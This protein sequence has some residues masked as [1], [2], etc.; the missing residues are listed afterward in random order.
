MTLRHLKMFIAV[1][2]AGSITS[3]AKTLFVAQPTVS[4]AIL[5]LERHYNVKL[6]DR[7]SKKLYLT[8]QGKRLLGYA[9]HVTSLVTE[10][11]QVSRDHDKSGLL[12]I[13]AS[14]TIGACL[15]PG[16][17]KQFM[18]ENPAMQVQAIVKNTQDIEALITANAIDFA[19]VEG[20][21][22]SPSLITGTFA[23]DQLVLACGRTHPLYKA[24][25]LSL[26]E[27]SR[28]DFI[29]RE[30]G[31]GTRE[32]FENTMAAHEVKWQLIWDCNGSD[33]LK[34]AAINGLGIA[35]IS[36]RL[37]EHELVTGE[38]VPLICNELSLKRSF[39][40]TYHKNK[41]L[42]AAMKKFMILCHSPFETF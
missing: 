22:H 11:E 36:Q 32:L 17:I 1:A 40:I 13:G 25:P 26:A 41:Y 38:L 39:C 42:T 2:D 18:W 24:G 27:L 8:E 14:L 34:S 5:E 23:E 21:I 33:V 15:L 3:A 35:V 12:K 7:L 9:R 29:V 20:I 28:D 4:Q 30:R 10:M 31:S 19:V 16:L 6:F 37:I